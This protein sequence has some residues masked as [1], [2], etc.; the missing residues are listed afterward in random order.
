MSEEKKKKLP[1]TTFKKIK[2]S[3]SLIQRQDQDT[4]YVK[5]FTNTEKEPYFVYKSL[6]EGW[7]CDCMAFTMGFTEDGHSPECKHIKLIKE[8]FKIQ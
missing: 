3:D 4:F 2:K 6:R 7:L 8:T 5:S 1:K